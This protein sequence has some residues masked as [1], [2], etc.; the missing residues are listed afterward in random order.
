MASIV[1]MDKYHPNPR[2]TQELEYR[3]PGDKLSFW[4]GKYP[5]VGKVQAFMCGD[6][7]NIALYGRAS[8]G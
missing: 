4:T 7:G 3:L 6:C 8:E 5:T 2:Y 1:L